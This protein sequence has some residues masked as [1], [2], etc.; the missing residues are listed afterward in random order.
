VSEVSDV[1][2]VVWPMGMGNLSS[3]PLVFSP[4]GFLVAIFQNGAAG[5]VARADLEAAG[6][7]REDLRTYTSSQILE[8]HDRYLET[9]SVAHRITGGL[10]EDQSDIELYFGYA[11]EGRTALWIHV[12]DSLDASRAARYLA[13]HQVLHFRHLDD[14][15][16][17]R[18]ESVRVG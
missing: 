2:E 6:I 18:N 14:D 11:R 7:A 8:D 3:R 9:R 1:S 5:E 15:K 4:K 12:P 10:T 16:G 17:T 13:N